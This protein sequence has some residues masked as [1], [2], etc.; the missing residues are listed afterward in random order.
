M[1]HDLQPLGNRPSHV[2]IVPNKVERGVG[3]IVSQIDGRLVDRLDRVER[4][5]HQTPSLC[6]FRQQAFGGSLRL[7]GI[8][9]D[10]R[11]PQIESDRQ[12]GGIQVLFLHMIA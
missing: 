5:E 10:D 4:V 1:Q 6:L 8:V 2:L 9:V 7:V 12:N 11:V 3:R